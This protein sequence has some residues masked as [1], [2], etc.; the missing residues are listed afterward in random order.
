[1]A[2]K[3]YDC[4]EPVHHHAG[5]QDGLW[6][7]S[8][9]QCIDWIWSIMVQRNPLDL[10]LERVKGSRELERGEKVKKTCDQCILSPEG[11]F[12]LAKFPFFSHF[13]S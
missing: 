4:T 8:H 6:K 7:R 10:Q 13:C 12:L 1:M 3:S 9:P 2:R 11:P 5:A